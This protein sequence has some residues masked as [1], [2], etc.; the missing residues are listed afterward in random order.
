MT[1]T[2]TAMCTLCD[3]HCGLEVSLDRGQPVSVFGDTSDPYTRGHIC[4]KAAAIPDIMADPDRVRTPLRR[5]GDRFEEVSWEEALTEIG[6]RLGR[7]RMEYD[8]DSVGTYLGN[9]MAHDHGGGLGLIALRTV[10]GGRNHYSAMSIDN[11]PR[12]ATSSVLYGSPTAIPVPDIERTDHLLMIGANPLVSNGSGMVSPDIRRR[13]GEMQ[14]RGRLVVVDPRRTQTAVAADAHHF[15]RP[16]T[17]VFFLLAL[18][19]EL[20]GDGKRLGRWAEDALGLDQLRRACAPYSPEAVAMRTGMPADSARVIARGLLNA[21]RPVVYGRM[22]TCVQEHGLLTTMALDLINVV[23]GALDAPGGAMFNHPAVDLPRLG[24]KLPEA[25]RTL[26]AM[27][28][29]VSNYPMFLGESPVAALREEITTAGE[30]QLRALLIS[31]GNPVLSNPG[32]GKLADALRQLELLVSVDIYINET[33]RLA[34]YILPTPFGFERD[35]F[36]MYFGVQGIRNFTG[37][38]QALCEPPPGVRSAYAIGVTLAASVARA[39]WGRI[40]GAAMRLSGRVAPESLI[41]GLLRAG[42][43]AVTL[44]QLRADPH[45]VDLGPLRPR[46]EEILGWSKRERLN[47]FPEL[48]QKGLRALDLGEARDGLVLISRR[49]LRSNNS[50]LH[51]SARLTRGKHRCSLEMH[52]DDAAARGVKEGDTVRLTSGEGAIE[53]PATVTDA[54]M[55]GVVCLPHGWGHHLEGVQMRVASARPGRS[56][57]DVIEPGRVDRLSG[58]AALSGQP[59]KVARVR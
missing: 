51:N 12:M 34:H 53:V 42:P 36:P 59:V 8:K 35:H 25:L 38:H 43:Q 48:L 20:L 27:R 16:G 19:H 58:T 26:G 39:R 41:A 56:V 6:E 46:L 33:S 14:R 29:R 49:T 44:K 24:A 23:I 13:L 1:I 5:V 54:I 57:N 4:P 28:T 3:A 7:I 55:P 17:D 31:A 9:P 2:K 52:P 21:S 11:L 32:G 45:T 18:L 37:F 15:I 47:L 10:L 40:A 50:W 30:G 22:G